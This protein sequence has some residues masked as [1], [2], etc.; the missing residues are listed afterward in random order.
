[1]F[2]FFKRK[3]RQTQTP[4]L[5]PWELSQDE[6]LL[7]QIGEY[8]Y[9]TLDALKVNLKRR[10]II[11][12]DGK[13]LNIDEVAQRLHET[14]PRMPVSDIEGSVISWLEEA[15]DPPGITDGDMEEEV[16]LEIEA[17]LQALKR[18]SRSPV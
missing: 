4:R 7:D 18:N 5:G 15:Y 6:Q 14:Q 1:M 12:K 8:T 10:K 17:W 9:D 3:E 11:W 13:A 16:Q 2:S